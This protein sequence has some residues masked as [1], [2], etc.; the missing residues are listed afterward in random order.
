MDDNDVNEFE[1]LGREMEITDKSHQMTQNI[2]L[3]GKIILIF[4]KSK[5]NLLSITKGA[6]GPKLYSP[7]F[8]ILFSQISVFAYETSEATLL[9]GFSASHKRR[10]KSFSH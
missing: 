1:L 6:L 5:R 2:F 9:C 8:L 3:K 7:V 4:H 10:A